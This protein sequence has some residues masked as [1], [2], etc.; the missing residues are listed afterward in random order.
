M[1]ARQRRRAGPSLRER[2]VRRTATL[3]GLVTAHGHRPL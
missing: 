3:P 1:V 2:P